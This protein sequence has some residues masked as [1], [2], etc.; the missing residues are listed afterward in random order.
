VRTEQLRKDYDIEVRWLAF[1]LHRDTPEDGVTLE[2]LF[3]GSSVDIKGI[4]QRLKR[5]ADGLGLPLTEQK[6]TYNT[7]LAQELAKWAEYK[8]NGDQFHEAVFRAY[9]VANK[10][11]GKADVLVDVAE[12]LGLPGEEARSVIE[13]RTFREAVDSDWSR[14]RALGIRAVPA[15]V[16]NGRE[17]TGFQPYDVLAKFLKTCGTIERQ[18]AVPE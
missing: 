9:F 4:I 3:S 7:R 17:V 13:S 5:V 14:S 12:S 8:G 15:F 16:V 2:E 18:N 11:I 1:P 10:N 6:R